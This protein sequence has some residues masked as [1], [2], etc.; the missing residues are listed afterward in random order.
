MSQ[1]FTSRIGEMKQGDHACLI[2]EN[3]AAQIEAVVPFFKAGLDANEACLYIPFELTETEIETAF[4]AKGVNLKPH[5]AKGT[6]VFAKNNMSGAEF[7]PQ[8]MVNVLMGIVSDSL[9]KGFNGLRAAGEMSWV[10]GA[11]C[12]CKQL[13]HYESLL[14][15]QFH[16]KLTGLCQY[17]RTRFKPEF[18]HG[19]LRNHSVVV[20]GNKVCR[21]FYSD[22]HLGDENSRDS[23]DEVNWMMENLLR[24]HSL[25]NNLRET[26]KTRD[27]F[28]SIASHE[29]KTPL[30]ALKLRT[31]LALKKGST[32]SDDWKKLAELNLNSIEHLT[33]IINSMT[34]V[35]KISKNL[36]Q[37]D[38]SE[39]VDLGEIVSRCVN[40]AKGGKQIKIKA[41]SKC[42]G[43]WDAGKIAQVISNLINNAIKY[44][45][46]KEIH[47]NL[48][49]SPEEARV[50]VKDH[51]IGIPK[52][53]Q[54][55]I[56]HLYERAVSYTNI[57]GLGIG[58]FISD[59]IAR[60]HGGAIEVSSQ[61]GRGSIFTLIL[62]RESPNRGRIGIQDQ[63][64]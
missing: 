31:N 4:A 12:S 46:G 49:S 35:T 29:L 3:P 51:G 16:T 45:N 10:L 1:G 63:K 34:D 43:Y 22:G 13:N 50:E 56:F 14:D 37:L 27:D 17:N 23:G 38:R 25:E 59:K 40:E 9:K 8:D 2:Y 7:V 48:V 20:V 28:L 39:D 18:I 15:K 21:N 61:P 42:L 53:D 33:A 6:F 26:I 36:L 62:P 24:F 60:A 41:H 55:R 57:S 58:L 30:A 52:A 47:I 44:G 54:R 11:Q 32:G 64:S 19:V 5:L